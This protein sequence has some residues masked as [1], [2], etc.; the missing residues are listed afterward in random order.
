[1]EQLK[2]SMNLIYHVKNNMSIND[3]LVSYFKLSNRLKLK[4]IRMQNV[5]LNNCFVDTRTIAKNGDT[6]TII[7]D[8]KEECTNIKPTKMDLQIVYED[9]FLLVLNKP[10]GVPVHPSLYHFDDSLSNGVKYYF[11]K[12]KLNKKIRPINRIDL[13]TSGLVLFAKCEYIQEALIKQMANNNFEKTYLAIIDGH[14]EK[15]TGT[16][17][18]PIIRKKNSIIERQVSSFGKSAITN[19][20]VIKEFDNYS[21]VECMLETGRTHQIRVHFAYL[22][23]PLIG[24]T[25]YGKKNSLLINRQALHSYKMEFTHPITNKK[26]CLKAPLPDDILRLI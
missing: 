10:S 5:L 20:K 7:L 21:L 6:V 16:I 11:D 25:L 8:Y 9:E 24:D 14:L 12:I 4:L 17:N 2:N 3:I 23:T 22:N 26:M 18:K 15:R 13:N 1:M 19:Y